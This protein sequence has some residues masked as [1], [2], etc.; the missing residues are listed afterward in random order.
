M[1]SL[2]EQVLRTAKEIVVKFIEGGRI[3]PTGFTE[4]FRN[5]YKTVDET[6]KGAVQKPSE[7]GDK[8]D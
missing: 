4:T 7:T 6:V 1:A 2:D 8:A 3:T 5:V